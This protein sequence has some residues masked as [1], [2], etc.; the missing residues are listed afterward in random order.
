MR[1]AVL[2]KRLVRY[3]IG[4]SLPILL[5]YVLLL[6]VSTGLYGQVLQQLVGRVTD[7]SGAVVE[8]AT[9]TVTDEGTGV[10][11]ITKSGPTG[12]W[13][14]PYLKP[15]S[16]TIAVEKAGFQM[17]KVT[18]VKL[19][20]GQLRR[21]D[22]KLSLGAV[23][24]TVAVTANQLALQTDDADQKTV[25]TGAVV[26]DL[27]QNFRNIVAATVL[28]A[29]V[30][31]KNGL[32]G[33]LP[34]GNIFNGMVFNSSSG[35]LSMD[36]ANDQGNGF[37]SQAY[38]P[39]LA[40]VQ[41]MVV[42]NT[43][44][45]AAAVGFAT[46]GGID[47]H[48]KSG[49]NKLHG[50]S[51]W[52]YKSTGLD[53]N[54][55]S[56]KYNSYYSPI[57][58]CGA[59][60]CIGRPS[61]KSNQYGFELDGPVVIPHLFNGHDKTF[62]TIA[63]EIFHQTTPGGNTF[64]VPGV[65]GQPSWTTP[66]DGYY[67]FGGLLES[68]QS[69]PITLYDPAS[70]NPLCNTSSSVANCGRKSFFSEGAPNTYSIPASRVNQTALNILKYY[71][72]PNRAAPIG[73][74]PWQN[75]YFVQTSVVSTYKNFLIKIDDNI[76]QKDRL[77]LRWGHWDQFQT[78]NSNG[79]P[80]SNPAAFGQ[81]PS[82]VG[83]QD[84]YAE[85]IHTF[86][87]NAI[88]DFKVSVITDENHVFTARQFNQSSLGLP[89]LSGGISQPG[90]LGFFPQVGLGG[91]NQIGSTASQYSSDN[92]LALAP[93]FTYIHGPHNLHIGLDN[94][95]FQ[96]S[97]KQAGGGLTIN[98]NANWT[99]ANATNT[100]DA[101]S[102][103]SVASF[104]LDN[105]YLTGGSL[106]QPAQQYRS[107]HYYGVFIQDNYKASKKLTL[108]LGLRYDFPNQAVERQNR[109][110]NVFLPGAES[111]V[112]GYAAGHG[113][114]GG[115]I[116]GVLT[117]SGVNGVPRTQVPRPWT[118]F[119]PRFGAAYLIND[120]TVLR[121]GVGMVYS[122]AAFVGAQTG[123]S[124]STPITGSQF[125][126]LTT[127]YATLTGA[128]TPNSLFPGGYIPTAGATLGP[129][130]GLGSAISYYN[131]QIRYNQT[132]SYSFGVQ[133]QLSRGDVLDISYVGK[134]LVA[135]TN[136]QLDAPSPS[137]FAQ[138]NAEAGGKPSKC[139]T[140]V[141]NP[142][143]GMTASVGNLGTI[144]PFQGTSFTAPTI[145]SGQLQLA[146]P[147]YSGVTEN[148]KDFK[149]GLWLNSL[150]VTET[151]RFANSLTSTVTYEYAR[152]MDN[153]GV[154]DY[155]NLTYQ[156]VQD[157]NDLNHRLTFSGVYQLPVG[158]GRMLLGNSNRIVDTLIGGW[159][160]GAAYVYESGRPWQPFCA[161]GQNAGLGGSTA[162]L[163]TPF[164]IQP[165]ST[166][167]K[168]SV[169]NGVRSIRG[170][171]PCVADRNAT[172]GVPVLRASAIAYGC[173]QANWAYKTQFAPAPDIVSVGIRLGAGSEFDA[174]LQK[175][176]DVY[177]GYEFILRCDAFNA[178]NHAVWQGNYGTTN[179]VNFGNII[180]G[181][182]A[183]SNTPRSLQLSGTIR[184]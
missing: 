168:V 119:E 146:Y 32:Y 110:T 96:A 45:D 162:C 73:S 144:N 38:P 140:N 99:Q 142:F 59:S 123:F 84:L 83:S 33:T 12:D 82:G 20:V 14:L 25:I 28:V 51:Y 64:S 88:V 103:L 128:G 85:W 55:Y 139:T 145:N 122:W 101:A 5:L 182:T 37:Q 1:D 71:P 178:T 30:G 127:P 170:T 184:W 118:F 63:G 29:G 116:N 151:H 126:F 22:T 134:T 17:E 34:Y 95:E 48:L 42:D 160:V 16:Y 129:Y 183:Q 112:S 79:F 91:F 159:K 167:R 143:A 148:G 10:V 180:E 174:N 130:V 136:V 69:T 67:Q 78:S 150:Q 9:V 54:T 114:S 56:N 87:P 117:F 125:S 61:H 109:Y 135:G 181:P 165:L 46:G 115:A 6:G 137:W 179:D 147:Q 15:D 171:A 163:E 50:T 120:K 154:M 62:F 13:V 41:E 175:A 176:F 74:A 158:R 66:V 80:A 155:S 105:G 57:P 173:S 2:V 157:A 77:T 161:G 68:D 138:C 44:Y 121:G 4:K 72:A 19:D 131:Q 104:M 40:T 152:I 107:N 65:F 27:P 132:W 24:E 53:A 60:Q 31:S 94:R 89:D 8:D 3:V 43:P 75:N 177:G 169:V 98:T 7:P 92:I 97:T 35:S 153:N 124:A 93:S 90:L 113:Y 70:I 52:Y 26:E 76:S 141:A 81:Y 133:R 47:V 86:S 102:G 164:G 36:G 106:V 108:N 11:L 18:G 21:T 149:N 100:A 156:R 166:G 39:L 172:T 111:P 49:T 23:T 58:G